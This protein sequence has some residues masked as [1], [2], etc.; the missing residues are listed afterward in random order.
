MQQRWSDEQ[1]ATENARYE[2]LQSRIQPHFLFNT[3]NTI[4]ALIAVAPQKAEAAIQD[5]SILLRK[6]IGSDRK[7]HNWSQERA[8]CQAYLGIEALRYGDRLCVNWQ[9]ESVPDDLA[10]P[11]LVLQPL[12]ENAIRHGIAKMKEA[13]TINVLGQMEK[14]PDQLGARRVTVCV[15]NSLDTNFLP[16]ASTAK[17]QRHASTTLAD[18]HGIA[19][20]NVRARVA[21]FYRD[22]QTGIER[23]SVKVEMLSGLCRITLQMPYICVSAIN[24]DQRGE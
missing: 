21:A 11:P 24:G 6:Q 9:V 19:L 2:A 16:Y 4:A 23:A 22:E 17:D 20:A 3:L 13:G 10:L 5:L 8:I 14:S 15:E 7:Q 18:E 12:L 1:K